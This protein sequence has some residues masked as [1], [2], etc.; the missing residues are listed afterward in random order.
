MLTKALNEQQQHTAFIQLEVKRRS[1]RLMNYFLAVYFIAGLVL[2]IFYDTWSIA[3]GVGGLSLIAYYSVKI[4]MPASHLS[5]YVLSAILGIFMAQYIYQMHGL[6]EMHFFAFIGSAI[7]ITYQNWKLQIPLTLIVIVH[8]SAFGYLQNTGVDDL[9]FTQLDYFS[10]QTFIIHIVIAAIIFFICG[11]WA[12]QL[13]KYSEHQTLQTMELGRL[14]KEAVLN[15]ERKRNEAVLERAN[16]ELRESN[17]QLHKARQEAEQANQAKSVFLA[18]M[19]H[20]IR[21]PMNGVIGMSSLLAE[22]ALTEQQRM[23]T[24]TIT[25]CGESLLNVINDI[26]DF[27]KIESGNLELEKEDFNLRV[28]I[29]DVLDIF[30]SKAAQIGIDL[31]YKIDENVPQQIVGDHLRLKQVLT[32][33][34]GNALK[35]TPKGEVFIGVHLLKSSFGNEQVQ[36][37]FEVRDSGIGIPAE[38]LHRLF[39]AF[40]Q[41]DTSTTRKYGG[42]GLGLAISEKLVTQM[43]GE[44]NV[45]SEPGAGSTFSFTILTEAGTK[46][47]PSYTSYNLSDQEGKKVLVVDDN[48]TNRA[49]L[50]NQLQQWKLIPVLASSGE[51]ALKIL[52]NSSQF[53]LVVTDMQ[54]PYMD[55]INLA[56]S[57]REKYPALP[58]ILLSSIGDEYNQNNRQLFNS[59][60]T[61]PVRQHV[62]CKHILRA[63]ENETQPCA[64]E[65]TVIEKVSA[66]FALTHPLKILVAED[67][68]I[69]QQVIIHLL[70]RM[71][72]EPQVVENGLQALEAVKQ[73]QFDLIFMDMQM[74]EMDGI[75]TTKAIRSELR[76]Q[77]VIIALTANTMQGDEEKCLQAGMNDYLGKPVKLEEIM[78]KLEKWS[79]SSNSDTKAA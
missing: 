4:L 57:I 78:Q 22:T 75:Q 52:A 59:I 34:I 43:G 25:I 68:H 72:Y 50:K 27:S 35:F 12:Y 23:Y 76:I 73:K 9:Y 45:E 64:D 10:L 30:G 55:G 5:E 54:M 41:V 37:G 8:H 77:P 3:I 29:E 21:T 11:L 51:E 38:K 47:L 66:S 79:A 32:N 49:I 16:Q 19:S 17:I 61:K 56:Q 74:P 13:K 24:Q 65:A 31:V 71:G 2:A 39:K 53:H 28:C 63:L 7:L 26:L 46:I 69:N 67:N 40:S 33:L 70:G 44:I 20:E 60:L 62:L 18:T 6:F 48:L 58:I 14:Q 36:L 15:E 1:D 42:T